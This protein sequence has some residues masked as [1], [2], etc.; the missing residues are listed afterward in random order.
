MAAG[1]PAWVEYR[2]RLDLMGQRENAPEVKAVR[3][4][5]LE[6]PRVKGLVDELTGW[7]GPPLKSHKSAGHLL[8][9]LAF[10]AE[11]GLR[12]DDPGMAAVVGAV[13]K[14][15]AAEGLFQVK[16]NIK[17]AYG[18]TGRDQYVWMLCDAPLVLYALSRSGRG[19]DGEVGQ[20]AEYL[21]E[22]VR[23]NGWPCAVSPELGKF[24]GPG[25]KADPCPYAT[26]LMLRLLAE[27]PEYDDSDAVTVGVEALLSLWEQ[28]KEWRPY[29][30]AMG[31]GFEKLKAPF[32]WYDI[33]HVADVLTRFT[34]ARED[35]RL[36]EMVGII[37]S[38][39][40]GDGRFTGESVWRDWK[41][42]DFGQKREPS[43]WVTLV[44]RRILE[45][46]AAPRRGNV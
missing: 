10:A 14:H 2:V 20:A 26:L 7:P 46:A 41:G 5:M 38:K 4:A 31:S 32:V 43:R 27:F 1:R 44:S 13:R 11:L 6:H 40:D 30:F 35:G 15:R 19:G 17:P 21:V 3:A 24:R 18:G 8:H 29:M 22:L 9:K 37:G 39:A 33:L 12:D 36:L 28:R 34:R 45:R 16:M 25:R 42:W 23:D